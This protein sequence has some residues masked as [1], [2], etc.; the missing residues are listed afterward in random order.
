MN[1][2]VSLGLW[3]GHC[4]SSARISFSFWLVNLKY[5]KC[6]FI[7][8]RDQINHFLF[9]EFL[10]YSYNLIF[11]VTTHTF[12]VA[13]SRATPRRHEGAGHVHETRGEG[14][15]GVGRRVNPG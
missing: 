8:C 9:I 15:G 7:G 1:W 13:F 11:T 14:E 4:R 2:S 6:T 12:C 3:S 5:R 10:C